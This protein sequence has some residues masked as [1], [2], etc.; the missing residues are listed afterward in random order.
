[1]DALF[2]LEELGSRLR[3]VDKHLVSLLSQRTKLALQVEKWKKVHN[4]PI[5]R[6]DI[7]DKRLEEIKNWAKSCYFAWQK[8]KR[9]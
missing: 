4:Q 6:L 2:N 9:N 7:E 3:K 8:R 5:I 1:M